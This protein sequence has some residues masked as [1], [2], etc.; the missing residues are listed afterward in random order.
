MPQRLAIV[1]PSGRDATVIE[2][3]LNGAGLETC[4]ETPDSLVEALDEPRAGGLIVAE[5]ALKE[6]GLLQLERWLAGQPPWSDL[7]VILLARGRTAPNGNIRLADRLGN[8]TILERPLHPVTLVSA[9]RAALR[10]RARQHEA[11]QYVAELELSEQRLRDSEAKYRDLFNTMDEG[12]CIIEFLDGPHGPL[13]DYV[14]VEANDAY[15]RHAG[16]PDVVGKKL[17]DMV[18][19]EADDWIARYRPVL[20][21][22]TPIRFE[23]ELVATGR[24]LELAAFRVEPRERRQVAVLFQDVTARRQ[25]E[26][27]LQQ[28]NATL[29]QRISEALAERKLL[30]DLVEG[31]DAFVQVV[32]RNFRILAINKAAADETER[33]VGKRPKPGDN[34]LELMADRPELLAHVRDVW[35]RAID[36]E[37]FTHIFEVKDPKRGPRFYEMNFNPLFGPSGKQVGAYQF[38]HDVTARIRDQQRL[39]EATSQMHEMAKLETLGQLT[40][41]VAHDFN[42]LLTPIVGALDMLRRQ[43]EADERSNRLISGAMQA[44]ERAA[45]LVQ[46]L[47]SFARRQHL[48]SR[49]VDVKALVEGMHDLMQR[50]IGPHIAV[51]VDTAANVPAARVDPGQLELALL[52]LAVNARDAMAGGGQIRLTLDEAEIRSGDKTRLQPGRYLR[53]AVTDT[54]MGMD[55]ATLARAIE[56]FFTTKG[57]GEGTGLG[58]SMVHGLAAQSGGALE[59]R[60]EVGKGTTAELWLP[61]A[62]GKADD[63]SDTD[64][65]LPK[66]PRRATIMIVDDENLV[67]AA[68]AEMLREMGHSVLEAATGSAALDRLN[69]G[70]D[71][72]LLITDYLMPGMRGSELIEDAR[73]L[74]PG[75][76]VLLLTGYANLAKG[77]AAGI[78]RLA[79][80]FREADLA[81]SVAALLTDTRPTRG[82]PRLRSV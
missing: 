13:S 70:E 42:N 10:A 9:A 8:V 45:T 19:D 61:A 69:A 72:D 6:D 3:I 80:P 39:A 71:V 66:Q 33:M 65:T 58:L 21:T 53:L 67:R 79:K 23:Q 46:R 78:P 20:L 59:I 26:T 37:S 30:A 76:P 1:A 38:A 15:A 32:D 73:S 24:H 63:F 64:D 51:R 52:N 14:H 68:T 40:G 36:G 74:R 47:L 2:G 60:S 17:R 31:T 56:P 7:P 54:G 22:G 82:K 43:H 77:E 4:V 41:G 44:A 11:E 5:E 50:T 55:E 57:Q 12:F 48:E 16:I 62:D 75:L 18:P 49:T 35:Q 25:A 28:L 27:A 81:R 29:E 34:K